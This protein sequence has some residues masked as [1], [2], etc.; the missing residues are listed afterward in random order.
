M[1]MRVA[2]IAIGLAFAILV[3]DFGTRLVMGRLY[4][5]VWGEQQLPLRDI[6]RMIGVFERTLY[7]LAWLQGKPEVVVG[8]WIVFKVAGKWKAWDQQTAGNE[9]PNGRDVYNMFILGNGI[10]ILYG[11]MGG[12]LILWLRET[13]PCWT[14]IYAAPGTLLLGTGLMALWARRIQRQAQNARTTPAAA[15]PPA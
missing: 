9:G 11:A 1:D 4:V 8:A 13:P 10:S 6:A 14:A 7:C 5:A 12:T 15:S 3:G 2:S